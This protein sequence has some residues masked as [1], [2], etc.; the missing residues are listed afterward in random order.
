M[1]LESEK[2]HVLDVIIYAQLLSTVS[3]LTSHSPLQ[4]VV[5]VLASKSTGQYYNPGQSVFAG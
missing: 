3:F 5:N 1:T 2:R 4:F